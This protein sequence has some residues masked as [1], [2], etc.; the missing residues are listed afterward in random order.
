[1][2][3]IFPHDGALMGP[4]CDFHLSSDDSDDGATLALKG[5]LTI[6]HVA[7]LDRAVGTQAFHTLDI[8]GVEEID[9]AGAWPA[10][11]LAHDAGAQIA[12]ASPQAERL[13]A[14]VK[15]GGGDCPRRRPSQPL[16]PACWAAPGRPCG[17]GRGRAQRGG[18]LRRDAG[19]DVEPAAPP[20]PHP[21]DG[22]CAPGAVG[23]Y[24]SL[25]I[26]GLM[27][28]LVGIVIAQQGAVQLEQFGAQ[29]YTVNLTGRIC[30]ANW[31]F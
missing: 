7:Q 8:S 5:A 19:G 2:L 28:F 10:W 11:R 9:T 21:L 25:T 1:V 20:A 30:C 15:A 14:T 26:I 13:L 16:P 31:A 24:R 23:G 3:G 4:D 17:M 6:G 29:I 22:H 27:S 18:I 12:G